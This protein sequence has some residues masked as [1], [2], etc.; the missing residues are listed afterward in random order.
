MNIIFIKMEEPKDYVTWLQVAKVRI[1][2]MYLIFIETKFGIVIL[3][4]FVY[5]S[6]LRFG[7]LM[8]EAIIR[9]CGECV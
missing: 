8:H 9:V 3:I 5:F 6:A 2:N 1:E 7:I 4:L